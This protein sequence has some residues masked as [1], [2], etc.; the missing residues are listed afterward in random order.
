MASAKSHTTV[1]SIEPDDSWPN[2]SEIPP[3]RDDR[4][5]QSIVQIDTPGCRI[6]VSPENLPPIPPPRPREIRG[7]SRRDVYDWVSH[8]VN[9]PITPQVDRRGRVIK[10]RTRYCPED[11]EER[12]KELRQRARQRLQESNKAGR[13]EANFQ[14]QQV[15]PAQNTS[16]I[17]NPVEGST[18]RYD[19][20]ITGTRPKTQTESKATGITE[21]PVSK[22][23]RRERPASAT[24]KKSGTSKRS[25]NV[26]HEGWK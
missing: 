1:Y 14:N 23:T 22:K 25:Q 12:Q 16:R 13:A 17:P 18:S 15:T 7:R 5:R 4:Q 26:S 8:Q 3:P 10:P 21:T 9:T 19:T 6:T 2:P 11:E 20:K 24:S